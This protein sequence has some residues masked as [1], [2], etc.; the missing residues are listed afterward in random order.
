V[1]LNNGDGTF[2]LGTRLNVS[3]GAS[4]IASADFNGDGKPDIVFIPNTEYPNIMVFLGNGDG[5]F[6]KPILT[7]TGAEYLGSIVV[8]D[9]NGDGKPDLLVQGNADFQVFLG[10]GD[11]TFSALPP[12]PWYAVLSATGDFNNDGKLDVAWANYPDGIAVALGNGDG[13]FQKPII[14]DTTL[15]G[16]TVFTAGDFNGDGKLDLV[17]SFGG[18]GSSQTLAVVL[19]NGDGTF[20]P[21]STPTTL[22]SPYV[23]AAAA[24][25]FNGDGKPDLL[26]ADAG[27]FA[28]VLLGNGDG[29]FTTGQ[30]YAINPNSYTDGYT[31]IVL[32][33]FNGDHKMDAAVGPYNYYYDPQNSIAIL[34]SR[35]DGSFRG[36]LA[37]PLNGAEPMVAADLNGDGKSD[38]AGTSSSGGVEILL[39]NGSGNEFTTYEYALPANEFATSFAVGDVNGDGKL[40][41]V[42]GA[43]NNIAYTESIIVMLG[44]G[45]GTFGSPIVS[46]LATTCPG[47][48]CY[49]V[50]I[51]LGDFNNDHKLDVAAVDGQNELV[52][53]LLGNGD[54]TFGQPNSF[55]AG[56]GPSYLFVADFNLDG[57]PDIAVSGSAGIGLFLGNG[58]GTFQNVTFIEGNPVSLGLV[59]DLNGDGKPDMVVEN[60]YKDQSQVLLGN[61]DGTF[62]ALPPFGQYGVGSAADLN[63]D[64]KLDLIGYA[65]KGGYSALVYPGNGDGTFGSPTTV[66]TGGLIGDFNGDGSPDLAD[67][68]DGWLTILFNTTAPDFVLTPAPGSKTSATVNAG[69][70]AAFNLIVSSFGWFS[71]TADLTC[72]IT[73]TVTPAPTCSVPGSVN[74]TKYSTVPFQ[75]KVATTAPTMGTM[76]PPGFLPARCHSPGP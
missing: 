69:Q 75:L 45:D 55:Y 53:V 64:G 41:L 43:V 21:P 32:A 52:F 5:T 4:A 44:N 1:L 10:K 50:Q 40:D 2:R 15:Q 37:L 38:L 23:Y 47:G 16:A 35:G 34:I 74:V 26:L 49:A 33:D 30:T 7:G 24:S 18:Y 22:P 48:E 71:G 68:P 29:T 14:S 66:P 73:P 57:K 11:G 58:D 70:G 54:G 9:V 28:H 39:N 19:G 6:Q 8:A 12:T 65:G 62:E 67:S 76:A 61:G 31:S 63:G 20:Q 60:Y 13:T 46:P 25:D 59:A 56:S 42:L 27:C 72:S 17:L 36:E 51:A 3:A